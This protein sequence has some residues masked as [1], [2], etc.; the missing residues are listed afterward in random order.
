[1]TFTVGS[2]I[3]INGVNQIIANTSY[4]QGALTGAQ[5]TLVSIAGSVSLTGVSYI[6]SNPPSQ[7]AIGCGDDVVWG[8]SLKETGVGVKTAT[9]RRSIGGVVNRMQRNRALVMV[10]IRT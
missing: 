4:T 8:W 10:L 1:M 6:Q 9:S 2:T 3:N 5:N 7:Y